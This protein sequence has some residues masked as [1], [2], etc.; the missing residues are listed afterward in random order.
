M[1]DEAFER[2][3]KASLVGAVVPLV[4]AATSL[5]VSIAKGNS[6]LDV[7]GD[8]VSAFALGAVP[9]VVAGAVGAA[10]VRF[11]RAAAFGAALLAC[12]AIEVVCFVRW[13]GMPLGG[14]LLLGALAPTVGALCGGGGAIAARTAP[15]G[16]DSPPRP[17][18]P[19]GEWIA[20]GLLAS[21]V[22]AWIAWVC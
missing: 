1:S 21:L 7:W 18:A 13:Q 8:I 10:A 16:C 9:C 17:R 6:S 11:G 4:V 19:R 15:I 3:C 5:V 2:Y 22:L 12:G 20:M 14:P